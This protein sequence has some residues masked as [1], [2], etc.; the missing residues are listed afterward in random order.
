MEVLSFR[1]EGVEYKL[2]DIM[3]ALNVLTFAVNGLRLM[4]WINED[5]LMGFEYVLRNAR[6]KTDALIQG[7]KLIL[8]NNDK[9]VVLLFSEES[10]S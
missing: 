9:R 4:E 10:E 3:S 5:E 1:T 7:M 6:L 2:Y 8:V